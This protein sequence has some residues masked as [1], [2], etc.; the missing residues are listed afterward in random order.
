MAANPTL[1]V[2]YVNRLASDAGLDG[3]LIVTPAFFDQ[4]AHAAAFVADL[5]EKGALTLP[6][7]L[8][9]ASQAEMEAG[10]ETA[11]RSM[12]PLR[13]KQAVDVAVAALI[14]A[15]PGAL[16]TLD[17]LAAALGD[18]ANFA[19]T[20]T[21]SLAAKAAK[22]DN[23]DITSL[24]KATPLAVKNSI[25]SG[26]IELDPY[27]GWTFSNLGNYFGHEPQIYFRNNAG[28]MVGRI[29]YQAN[30]GLMGFVNTSGGGLFMGTYG[31][32][33]STNSQFDFITNAS[34][35]GYHFKPGGTLVAS[36]YGSA[37]Y[38]YAQSFAPTATYGSNN[39]L[40]ANTAFVQARAAKVV[41]VASYSARAALTNSTVNIGDLV[42]Q[43]ND[44]AETAA[45]AVIDFTG[46]GYSDVQATAYRGYM[47]E[48]E[49]ALTAAS[50]GTS[51]NEIQVVF[52]D[53]GGTDMALYLN[54]SGSMLYFNYA[55]DNSGSIIPMTW[56][57]ICDAI[58]STWGLTV[59]A[60]TANPWAS[61]SETFT[62]P[63]SGG[64]ASIGN[65]AIVVS[66]SP[67]DTNLHAFYWGSA[68]GLYYEERQV[69]PYSDSLAADL[70][71]AMSVDLAL[72]WSQGLSGNSVSIYANSMGAYAGVTSS[73][74]RYPAIYNT[75]YAPAS[76]PQ[77]WYLVTSTA[78]HFSLLANPS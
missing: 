24:S 39:G 67:G 20:I 28:S 33:I 74:D 45:S 52:Q 31:G 3:I 1:P 26:A 77:R 57:D 19:S 61:T 66:P 18:D 25:N 15:A 42:L 63:L 2:T 69:L 54:Q 36:F 60:S 62:M 56:N 73:G 35:N 37:V 30:E 51:G 5:V 48:P 70:S 40:I 58:N 34:G 65:T 12:S 32:R 38:L 71:Y 4:E 78:P 21:T 7:V 55:T 68:P 10:T 27:G 59:T 9:A 23:A 75:P 22:G 47:G 29:G 72:G 11:L 43:L 76:G 64:K 46:L 17:E 16:N 50:A 13:I 6:E 49:L 14:A 41:Q 53:P 44:Y 8:T